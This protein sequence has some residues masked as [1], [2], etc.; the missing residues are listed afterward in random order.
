VFIRRGCY[1]P[2]IRELMPQLLEPPLKSAGRAARPR[3]VLQVIT[4]SHM[5]GA[6]MQLVRLTRRM[7]ARG[8]SM[9]VVV[10]SNS[11]A[12]A[13]FERLGIE[14][15]RRSIS[16]KFNPRA[17]WALARATRDYRPEIIQSTLSSASWWSG[18]LERMGGPPTLGHVQGFTSASWHRQQSHLLAVSNAV[19][20]DM[21]EQG[22]AA[23]KITVL[24][25]A[26]APEEF[27]PRR[28]IAEVRA[29]LGA[30]DDTFIVGT[31]AH[32]S[33]KKGYREL[34]AAIPQVLEQFPKTQF[35]VAGQGDLRGELEKQAVEQGFARQVRFL[36]FRRDAADLMNAI[37]LFALP[38]HREPC[39]LV[40]I[41][42]A[43]RA[44]PIVAC[45]AGG[46]PESIADGETG[47]LVP[48]RD[49]KALAEAILTLAD[50]RNWARRMG[51]AGRER[52]LDIFSW[53]RF[54]NTLEG[55]YERMLDEAANRAAA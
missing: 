27:V 11:P 7:E 16:G 46:A 31:I 49:A 3:R 23:D 35:W 48:P 47:L 25:N 30:D 43:L 38:S 33:E 39:A 18:W 34:F 10:K 50:H 45:R 19:K 32:L 53:E 6:E 55:V 52:A 13:E 14:I 42:A 12:N 4:P 40:Y 17:Y 28:G 22:I 9:P 44:K 37:D 26:L 2:V 21:V 15:D 41:E 5:S 51:Q 8:H 1:H 29:E 36:G 54:T 20:Q 24:Y